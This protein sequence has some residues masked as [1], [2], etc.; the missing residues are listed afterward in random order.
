M[1]NIIA[2]VSVAALIAAPALA[3]QTLEG[4]AADTYQLDKTHAFLTWTVRHNGLSGYTVNFT[5]FDATLEFDPED[6][7]A[8]S[9]TV[10]INPMALETNYPDEAKRA[11]W[12]TELST[13]DRFLNGDEFPEITFVSTSAEQTGDF[14]GTVTG[15]L[16]FLGVTRPVTMDVTYNGTANVP[17][18]GERDLLGF[19]A[20]TTIK[21][22]DF[23]MTA[24]L[25]MISDETRIEFSGEFLQNE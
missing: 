3:E 21:R 15:D 18:Y 20:E 12:H 1:R 10:T 22:S 24:M 9:I 14:T 19:S 7:S 25:G 17:W 11:E 8:S 5:D 23:G 2:S 6:L 16:T 4:V 13:D